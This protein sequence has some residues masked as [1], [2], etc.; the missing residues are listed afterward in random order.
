MRFPWL[1][2]QKFLV[3]LPPLPIYLKW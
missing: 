2:K 1:E 3:L